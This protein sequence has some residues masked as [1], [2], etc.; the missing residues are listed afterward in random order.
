MNKTEFLTQ[1]EQFTI[2]DP[3]TL[4]ALM[5]LSDIPGRNSMAVLSFIAMLDQ[6]LGRSAPAADIA[7]CKT[8]DDLMHLSGIKA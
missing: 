2:S 8:I 5:A 1:L 3:G 4:S 7:I 6:Q